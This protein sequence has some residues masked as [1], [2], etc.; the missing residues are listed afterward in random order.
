MLFNIITS[1]EGKGSNLLREEEFMNL[2]LKSRYTFPIY[3]FAAT[4]TVLS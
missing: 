4:Y 1:T 2:F 3:Q